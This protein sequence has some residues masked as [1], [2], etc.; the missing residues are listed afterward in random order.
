MNNDYVYTFEVDKP[1]DIDYHDI[2]RAGEENGHDAIVVTVRGAEKAT[3]ILA[4]SF[5]EFYKQLDEGHVDDI[6]LRNW[7]IGSK[8]YGGTSYHLWFAREIS[9][10]RVN[11]VIAEIRAMRSR[12]TPINVSVHCVE[13]NSTTVKLY[14]LE[15]DCLFRLPHGDTLFRKLSRKCTG[16]DNAKLH[17]VMANGDKPGT[18]IVFNGRTDV[19]PVTNLV[20]NPAFDVSEKG[21]DTCVLAPMPLSCFKLGDFFRFP[22]EFATDLGTVRFVVNK[23]NGTT[24][25]RLIC[26]G[27]TWEWP[28]NKLAVPVTL[29]AK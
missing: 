1:G 11:H 3:V 2:C 23:G 12:V 17:A 13:S 24:V 26:S 29:I 15:Q 5:V 7:R 18:A 10:A 16:C 27:T 21:W 22:G 20:D 4:E 14:E 25:S 28:D 19:I 6:Y 9:V 8:Y